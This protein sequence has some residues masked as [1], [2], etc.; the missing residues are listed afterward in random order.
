[1]PLQTSVPPLPLIKQDVRPELLVDVAV[2]L[3][4]ERRAGGAEDAD[5][6]EIVVAPR[7]QAR[8]AAG[9]QEGRAHAHERRPRLLREPP[10]PAG[11]GPGRVAVE[12]D[13]R[14]AQEQRSDERV[15]HHPGGRREPLQTPARLEVPAQRVR[16]EV[17]EQDA[18]VPVHD[19]LRNARRAGREQHA[20]RVVEGDR[21]EFQ[22][23]G[24]GQQLAP[25]HGVGDLVPAIG[26]V[27]D[28]AQAGQRGANRG[29]FGPAVDRAVAEAVAVDGQQDHGIEL[30]EAVDDAAGAELGSAAGPDRAD[31]RR[32][33]ER[34]QRLGDVGHVGDDAIARLDTEAQEA[35]AGARDRLAQV[36]EGELH[37][38][39]RLRVGDHGDLP[40]IRVVADQVLGEVEAR[41]R[42]PG[43]RRHALGRDHGGIRGVRLDSRE[44]PDRRPEA[45]QVVDGP[46]LELVVGREFEAALALE[47]A[48][49]AP[50]LG[51]LPDVR[52]RRP[53]DAGAAVLRQAHRHARHLIL[54]FQQSERC[55][56]KRAGP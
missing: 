17:L 40:G 14:R 55:L 49:V 4:R 29:H 27:H 19:G 38:V 35:R 44:V 47:P 50:D 45:R 53:E 41:A 7:L 43:G 6:A 3:G 51:R 2:A 11:V 22:R 12:H 8:L 9:H 28:V 24:L 48:D 15:P 20:Q 37:A 33:G 52:R 1:M 23:P 25:G 21:Q 34:D 31:A 46:A 30:R 36:R 26:D 18:A 5:R 32:R 54:P 39:A 13:D 42:E 16:L 10:L 56:D